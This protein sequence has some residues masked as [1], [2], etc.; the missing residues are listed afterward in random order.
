[1]SDVPGGKT[2]AERR[3]PVPHVPLAELMSRPT[4][5]TQVISG[6]V[7]D[8]NAPRPAI[9]VPAAPTVVDVRTL[10]PMAEQRAAGVVGP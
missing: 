10:G 5:N 9:E 6:V 7:P 8:I 1:M 4:K 2:A 3:V